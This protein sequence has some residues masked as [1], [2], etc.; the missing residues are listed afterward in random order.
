M[1]SNT[2]KIENMTF[3]NHCKDGYG[4]IQLHPT[5]RCNLACKHCYSSSAPEKKSKLSHKSITKFLAYAVNYGFKGISVSGGE[6]FLYPELGLVLEESKKLNYR[7]SVASNGMLLKSSKAKD[8]LKYV[9]TI[10]ISIDGDESLHNEI[11]N[12]DKA[13]QKMLEGIDVIK[14]EKMDFGFIHTVTPK[15][16]DMM[17]DLAD[18]AFEQGA[19][20]MQFH[21]LELYGRASELMADQN[22]N[23]SLLHKIYIIGDYLKK[24]FHNKMKI[25]LDFLHKDYIKM[26]PQTVAYYGERY[27]PSVDK[28]SRSL[29]SII[30]DER[31]DVYP[32]SYGFSKKYAIGNIKEVEDGVDIF[33]R[34]L[35]TW[36]HLYS[37]LESTYHQIVSDEEDDMV[38]WTELVVRNSNLN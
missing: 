23:Q 35:K 12:F 37:I 3:S 21:P 28:I 22:I 16:W 7:T 27:Q 5:L 13:Y 11:R 18:F 33:K 31:G 17:I 4:V 6:P 29:K 2:T 19:R 26:F 36:Q 9:D 15:S 38:M 32:I 1:N 34:Y 8:T 10:A 20:L 25:Q 30:V 14:E 24:K